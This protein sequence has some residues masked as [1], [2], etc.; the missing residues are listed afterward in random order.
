MTKLEGKTAMITGC[1]RGFGKTIMKLF[2]SEGAN[3]IAC[4]R[5]KNE[6]FEHDLAAVAEEYK[7]TI[8]PIYFD[9]SDETAIKAGLKEIKA[10]KIPVDILVNNAGIAHLAIVPFTRMSDVRNVFQ[11]NYFAQLQIIQGMYNIL[12]KSKGCI[13]NMASVAGID[14]D[15][16][17]AVYGATKASMILLTKVLSKEM[18]NAGVRVNAVAPGLSAT[19]LADVMGDK[20]KESMVAQSSMHRL[21]TPEEIAKTVLFLASDDASFITG[22]IIRVDGGM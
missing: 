8:T 5:T 6:E 12:S 11:I 1:N 21:G 7:V 10:L 16:G 2:A 19:D 20:A 4:A 14:G 15:A 13:V 17:N 18:A 9:L 22:Q 3:I